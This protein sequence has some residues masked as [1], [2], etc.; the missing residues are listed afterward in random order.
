MNND[1]LDFQTLTDDERTL[2]FGT[3]IYTY[4]TLFDIYPQLTPRH[5]AGSSMNS[6]LIIA[7]SLIPEKQTFANKLQKYIIPYHNPYKSVWDVLIVI[8][9]LYT[10]FV[11]AFE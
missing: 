1:V 3:P 2:L 7:Q 5:S 4:S 6:T 9:V 10:S 8:F 11:A